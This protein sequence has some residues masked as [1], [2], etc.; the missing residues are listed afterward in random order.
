MNRLTHALACLYALTAVGL[1]RCAL[2]NHQRGDVV[3]TLFFAGAAVLLATAIVHHSY[4]RDELRFARAQLEGAA[5]PPD[6]PRALRDDIA[7]GWND[8]ESAC[9]LRAWESHGADHEPTTCT[10]K[11]QTT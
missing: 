7:L 1:L 10:R 3:H 9:C 2:V 6:I 8:L 4:Q 5:R 11:D